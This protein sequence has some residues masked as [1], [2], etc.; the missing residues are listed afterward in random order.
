MGYSYDKPFTFDR[1]VRLVISILLTAF[2][3]YMI[4]KLS[5]A[6]LPFLVAWLIAYL[7]NPLVRFFQYKLKIKNRFAAVTLT[8]IFVIGILTGVIMLIAPMVETEISQINHLIATYDLRS[9]NVDGLPLSISDF[10]EEHIDFKALR[11]ALSRQHAQDTLKYLIPALQGVVSGSISFI[12]GFTV[13]FIILL[14]LIF[15]LMDYDRINL[16]WKNLVPYKYRP[17]VERITI[18]V[19]R[20]MNTYFRHQAL[21]C[22]I[23]GTL[24]A[25]SFQIIGLPLAILM[26]VL[27]AILHM[28]PYMHTL[29]ILPAALLCWLK[30]SQTGQSF[31]ALMGLILLIYLAIQCII[32]LILVPRIMGK[33][34]GLNPAIILL[35]LSIWGSLL[36]IVG[37]IIA[38]PLT[39]LL[40]SYYQQFIENTAEEVVENPKDKEQKE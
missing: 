32:D 1:V 4:Y 20:S 6:L 36:G 7:L 12:L 3:I 28:V 35:S 10:L 26:G 11:E 29:S 18:D 24:F 22:I 30:V 37:M 34:M 27:I 15:I 23:V 39:T 17:F 40:L 21:I 31:W 2:S 19:E 8:F 38:I 33:A 9:L 5:D 13:I 16:L 14:Y 25:I